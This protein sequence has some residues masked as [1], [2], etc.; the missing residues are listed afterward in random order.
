MD[1][2]YQISSLELNYDNFQL[3]V[4]ILFLSLLLFLFFEYWFVFNVWSI[5]E[6]FFSFWDLIHYIDTSAL[7]TPPDLLFP[8]PT[9][10]TLQGNTDFLAA[11][12]V[13]RFVT[14][15]PLFLWGHVRQSAQAGVVP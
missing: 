1:E 7:L 4:H 8:F 10:T 6:R 11:L 14:A 15:R 13:P 5:S 9:T 3:M 2:A 12:A